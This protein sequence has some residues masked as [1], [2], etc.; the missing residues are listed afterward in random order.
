MTDPSPKISVVVPV[1]NSEPTIG[2]LLESLARQRHP[3][4][5]V[6]ILDDGSTDRTLELARSYGWVKAVALAR[7]GPSRA[8]NIGISMATGEYVAFTDGDCVLPPN[9]LQELERGFIGDEIAGSGGDQISPDDET[10]MGREI[11]DIFKLIG[12]VTGYIKTS[13]KFIFVD[14]NPSCNSIYRKPVLEEIGGFDP[15]LWPGEDVDLDFRITRKGYKLTYNPQAVVAHYRPSDLAGFRRMMFRYGRCQGIL[16]RRYGFFRRMQ[17]VPALLAALLM[18][19]VALLF[20]NPLFAA[21]VPA[22]MALIWLRFALGTREIILSARYL[23]LFI[24]TIIWWNWGFLAGALSGGV[25][26][27]G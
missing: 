6:I 23:L 22:A 26:A 11:Q 2:K 1:Y 27:R 16:T 15:E 18:V 5:E 17:L 4:Y 20:I 24:I 21:L 19:F 7:G 25:H 8:R 14:H 13:D 9:W 12:F 3:S 10:K